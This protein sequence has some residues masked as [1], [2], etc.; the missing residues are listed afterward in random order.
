LDI[1]E[2]PVFTEV[3]KEKDDKI[4]APIPVAAEDFVPCQANESLPAKED[5]D[6][7]F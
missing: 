4:F 5:D 6:D 1:Q 7:W 2:E 3:E